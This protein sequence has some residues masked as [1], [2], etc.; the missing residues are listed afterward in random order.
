MEQNWWSLDVRGEEYVF[1]FAPCG[2]LEWYWLLETGV[3]QTTDM[4]LGRS[5]LLDTW[6]A[7]GVSD[8]LNTNNRRLSNFSDC[9]ISVSSLDGVHQIPQVLHLLIC[10]N[11]GVC[12]IGD[13]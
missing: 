12:V 3:L 6:M 10:P 4:S 7:F 1:S 5:S 9:C 8:G 13:P 11:T 2:W